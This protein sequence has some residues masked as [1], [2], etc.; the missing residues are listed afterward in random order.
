[1]PPRVDVTQF[2]YCGLGL[3]S[4]DHK[5]LY[6][7]RGSGYFLVNNSHANVIVGTLYHVI[8]SELRVL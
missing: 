2:H 1:M 8:F 5:L 4:F 6:L 3:W 7:V